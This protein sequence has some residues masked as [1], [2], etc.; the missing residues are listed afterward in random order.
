MRRTV[1][2]L[3]IASRFAMPLFMVGIVL[4]QAWAQNAQTTD[5]APAVRIAEKQ[6]IASIKKASKSSVCVFAPGGRGG[7][8]GVLISKDGFA[9]TNYHVVKPCGLYMQCSLNDG[10]LYDAVL[11]GVDPVGD[12]AIIQLLGR[13]DFPAAV[14]A[15]S[16]KVRV[17]DWC[18]AVGNPFLLATDF[19]PTVTWGMVSGV[20]RYQYPAKTLL[21]YADCIQTDAAINPGNSGGPL[22]D[23][24]GDVI[25]INGRGSFEKRGRVNVGVGYAISINQIKYFRDHLMSGRIV[26][27]ATLGATVFTDDRGRVI[28]DAILESSDAYKKGLRFEDEIV[29]FGGRQIGSVNQ[30][31]NVLGIYP[32]GWRVALTY[33]R[34]GK[35][36]DIV[37]R[38]SGVHDAE[39]LT[40]M[41][42][43]KARPAAKPDGGKKG[44]GKK[45]D[46]KKTKATKKPK[47]NAIPKIALD[48]IEARRGF[49]NYYFN[50]LRQTQIWEAHSA[51]QQY[52]L[53]AAKKW[54][55]KCRASDGT[56]VEIV[57]DDEKSGIQWGEDAYVLDLEKDLSEQ[58]FPRQTGGLLPA[59]H[60]WRR[61][62][63][64]GPAKFGSVHYFGSVPFPGFN[65]PPHVFVGTYDVAE[66][67]F[68]FDRETSSL[69]ALE[70]FLDPDGN[71]VEVAFNQ[72]EDANGV[73]LPRQILTTVSGR[74]TTIKIESITFE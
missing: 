19:Q 5:V 32:K 41:L 3:C 73:L 69:K 47:P 39:Q 62:L 2:Q 15:D 10:N 57:L 20:N 72:F 38:L 52:D 7:G 67:N 31:K 42:Q 63:V 16:D 60:I 45:G 6:R 65:S 4:N 56:R 71:A 28:V 25:G 37:V 21:E 34:E 54:V 53:K 66:T 40:E 49:S 13:D 23:A 36:Y 64:Q 8:S 74:P 27:H 68:I 18:F 50:R 43:G 30:F 24:N 46:G 29:S 26:D 35:N 9:L 61:L 22:F 48:R 59:L 55:M 17:G 51:K 14:L 1:R 70:M 12:V 44:D 33:R 11:V 58:L